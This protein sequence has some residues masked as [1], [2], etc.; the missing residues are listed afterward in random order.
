[1]GLDAMQ[2]IGECGRQST[3]QFT[4]VESD[5]TAQTSGGQGFVSLRVAGGQVFGDADVKVEVVSSADASC[6]GT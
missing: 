1:M 2:S 4:F 6:S 3:V 5:I